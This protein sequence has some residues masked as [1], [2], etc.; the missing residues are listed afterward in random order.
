[1]SD[2]E[3]ISPHNINIKHRSDKNEVKYQLGDYS[4]IQYQI[5]RIYIIA[6]VWQTVRRITNEIF[7]VEGLIC[8]GNS[9]ISTIRMLSTSIGP[10]SRPFPLFPPGINTISSS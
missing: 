8:K 7:G 1:M 4:L 2:S 9:R 6:I 10:L 3:R 5:P